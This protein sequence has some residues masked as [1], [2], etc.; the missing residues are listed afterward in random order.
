MN[1]IGLYIPTR[2]RK[3]KLVNCVYSLYNLA[4]NKERLNFRFYIDDDDIETLQTVLL[5]KTQGINTFLTL[6]KRNTR[7]H[8]DF[9]NVMFKNSNDDIVFQL[10]DDCLMRTQDWDSII[11]DEFNKIDDKILLVYGCDGIHNEGFAPHYAL[12]RKWVEII[13]YMT[14]KYF[15][16]DW[17]D[18]W[19]FEIAKKIDRVKFLPN[20]FLEHMHWTQGKMEVDET[21]ILTEQRR[22]ASNNESIFRSKEMEEMRVNDSKIL[23]KFIEEEKLKKC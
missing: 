8:S 1:K 21:V 7:P 16:V 3:E 5:L 22:R 13:G 19:V 23:L 4:K 9:Y 17:A 6:E 11:E 2:K 14:P 12:H 10:G 15:T 20:L 18:T